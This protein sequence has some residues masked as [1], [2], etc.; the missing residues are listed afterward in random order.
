MTE[1]SE[2]LAQLIFYPENHTYWLDSE[3]IPSV[4]HVLRFLSQDSYKA[5][6]PYVL[7]SAAERGSRI[8]A[9]CE[10]YDIYGHL[11]DPEEDFDIYYYLIAYA[12]FC[13]KHK[14]LWVEIETPLT[15]G[16]TAGTVDRIG[17]VE[18]IPSFVFVDIKSSVAVDIPSVA[19]QTYKYKQMYIKDH[20]DFNDGLLY[21]LQ[22][23]D[24]GE[25]VFERLC[26]TMG[27][28]VWEVC[29]NLHE[30]KRSNG[31]WITKS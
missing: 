17:K 16:E 8:H 30:I 7:R 13:A 6:D 29:K 27:G 9:A 22:L 25:F 4:T 10:T 12:N 31:Q 19:A 1:R 24:T 5:I 28:H 15:D 20:A 14:P 23:K 2:N 18:G 3:E 21:Y 26:E 11:P